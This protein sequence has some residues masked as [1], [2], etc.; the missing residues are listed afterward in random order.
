MRIDFVTLFPEM[1]ETVMAE[2]IIG[3]ARKKGLL[4]VYC[5]Q[6]RDFADNK[7][8]RV[9][10]NPFG[11]GMGMLL[12]AEPIARCLDDLIRR[13]G[14]K[15]HIVYLS[16]QGRTLTQQH[17]RELAE[18]ENLTL[19]CGHYEGID[20]R[21][22]DEYVD[23][24]VSIG[25]YVLTGGELPALIVADAVSRMIDGVLSD[26]ECFEEESHFNGLLEYPQYTRPAE[27]RGRQVPEV[28]LSGHH[29]NV[30]KWRHEQSL[31]R[32]MRKR[33]ELLESADLTARDRFF[34]EKLQNPLKNVEND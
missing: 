19:L 27:W 3:R 16:P 7:H 10:D 1:C 32:T 6:L 9:D 22:V 20:E 21:I 12:M 18:Y 28:L 13:L 11:G 30:Q 23:E 24:E 2:S 15:P 8:N 26:P 25:D 29:G 14:K 5:H 31:L 33:P 17:V 34:V 4:Q